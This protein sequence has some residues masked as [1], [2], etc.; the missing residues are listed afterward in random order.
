MNFENLFELVESIFRYEYSVD[1]E[2]RLDRNLS[3]LLR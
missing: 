2:E 3:K 1:V